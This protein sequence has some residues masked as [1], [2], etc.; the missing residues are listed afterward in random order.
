MAVAMFFRLPIS[1][2]AYDCLLASLELDVSPPPGEILHFAAE[3]ADGLDVC[4]L[5]RTQGAAE[6]FFYDVLEPALGQLGFD[7]PVEHVIYPLHNLY[8]ADL[9]TIERIGAVSLPGVA[10]GASIR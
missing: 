10:S 3:T 1:T 6:S 5:W 8:A 2:R 4:E 7:A 9:D